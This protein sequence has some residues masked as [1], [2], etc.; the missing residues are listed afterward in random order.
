[1][2]SR[3]EEAVTR[4]RAEVAEA[5]AAGRP[6]ATSGARHSLG[7]QSLPLD[8]TA[9]RFVE[10]PVRRLGNRIV[11]VGAGTSWRRVISE[12]DPLGLSPAVMQSNSDFSVGGTFCVNA[13]GWAIPRGPFGSS[14]LSVRMMLADGT[15]LTASRTENAELFALALGGYGLYG[16]VLDLDLEV[17][18][19]ALLEASF[20]HVPPDRL[21]DGMSNV[22]SDMHGFSRWPTRGCRWR[23]NSF[24]DEAL[25]VGFRDRGEE[26]HDLP[27]VADGG[28]L[29]SLAREVYRAQTGSDFGKRFRWFLEATV[30]P[31]L[32]DRRAT[33]NALLYAP[34]AEYASRDAGRTDILHEYFVPPERLATFLAA[35]RALIP[36]SGQELL[37]VT[38]RF[39]DSD[40]TSVLAYAPA[41]RLAAVMA[42]SQ[43]MTAAA[44]TSMRRLTEGLIEA[45]LSCGGTFYLPYRLH[46]RRDQIARGYP[47]PRGSARRQA[48]LDPGLL[49]RNRMWDRY[50]G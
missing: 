18:P 3:G 30:A 50:F 41:P 38:V 48:P 23:A 33:R 2:A 46:A 42:F 7:G 6:V 16:I 37:N 17:V 27:P 26:L 5:R 24:L 12:L 44:E 28:A 49:F 1:M 14:V 21:A 13:H 35:C 36:P 45:A 11:R 20:L 10:E 47:A 4:L 29:S 31:A 22:V 32:V 34:V 8:G 9:M 39:V 15:L 43:E 40:D 25:L 19:N